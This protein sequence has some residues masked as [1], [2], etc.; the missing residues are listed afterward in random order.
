MAQPTTTRAF[1]ALPMFGDSHFD[2]S[3]LDGIQAED[4]DK[5]VEILAQSA[6]DGLYKD[7]EG[8]YDDEMEEA[9]AQEALDFMDENDCSLMFGPSTPGSGSGSGVD[10]YF[11]NSQLDTGI[12]TPIDDIAI[13]SN[14][15]GSSDF[16][17][18][19]CKSLDIN[20]YQ[21]SLETAQSLLAF[22]N[23]IPTST[24]NDSAALTSAETQN[25]RRLENYFT[26]AVSG[27]NLSEIIQKLINMNADS[28]QIEQ[29][30]ID[31]SAC[32]EVQ[33]LMLKEYT[34]TYLTPNASRVRASTSTYHITQEHN[35][36]DSLSQITVPR[37]C[38]DGDMLVITA[39]F[40]LG[41]LAFL[42]TEQ[43][44]CIRTASFGKTSIG[45]RR[46]IFTTMVK[47][48]QYHLGSDLEAFIA[49]GN[50]GS[51]N[52]AF[53]LGSLWQTWMGNEIPIWESEDI[54]DT[55]LYRS[56]H[57]PTIWA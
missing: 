51:V 55:H 26:Q 20:D 57:E 1:S 48:I 6:C 36:R 42:P 25:W 52:S 30:N 31:E 3:S 4:I 17:H 12:T 13:E 34:E 56:I 39:A 15:K 2:I 7:E 14:Y 28:Q 53:N 43:T 5:V 41:C 44:E 18:S 50:D 11:E 40:I 32:I 27:Q 9:I 24:Q 45:A 54:R 16:A 38:L 33:L 22:F 46:D 29:E 37:Q 19:T 10:S 49:V 23:V 21:F 8:V 35:I 47:F